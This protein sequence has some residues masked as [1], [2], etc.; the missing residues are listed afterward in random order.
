MNETNH[1]AHHDPQDA[2]HAEVDL[3]LHA[4]PAPKHHQHI[5]KHDHVASHQHIYIL[6]IIDQ[7]K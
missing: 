1:D 7:I 2:A 6:Q 3:L 5:D 4:V